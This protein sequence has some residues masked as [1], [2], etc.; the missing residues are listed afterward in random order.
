MKVRPAESNSGIVFVRTDLPGSPEV[1]AGHQFVVNTQLAT[2]LGFQKVTVGTVE[3]LLAALQGAGLDNARVELDGPEVPIMDGSAVIFYEAFQRAGYQ[4]QAQVRTILALRQKVELKMGE[5]W[6]LQSRL[7]VSKFTGLS[8]GT[9][10]RL[11]TKSFVI[12]REEHLSRS[13]LLLVP[14]AS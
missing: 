8:S 6:A 11:V 12:K 13:W 7:L 1:I 2:T 9:T 10:L 5:K 14:S 4:T 3:H